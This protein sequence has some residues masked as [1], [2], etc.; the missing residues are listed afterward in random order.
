MCL[1]ITINLV[2]LPT[3]NR[4]TSTSSLQPEVPDVDCARSPTPHQLEPRTLNTDLPL[5]VLPP[6]IVEL[7][8][9]NTARPLLPPSSAPYDDYFQTR[10][11]HWKCLGGVVS[12]TKYYRHLLV[13]RWFTVVVLREP[14]DWT[15]VLDPNWMG[16]LKPSVWY[17]AYPD[18]F[19]LC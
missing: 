7:I 18:C 15:R 5:P 17:V 6:E 2:L 19:I 16:G 14:S 13:R 4:P 10:K 9:I 3:A 12:S 11:A 8:V 1:L